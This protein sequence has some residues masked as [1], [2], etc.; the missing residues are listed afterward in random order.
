MYLIQTC[1]GGQHSSLPTIAPNTK[2]KWEKSVQLKQR[3]KTLIFLESLVRRSDAMTPMRQWRQ[4]YKDPNDAMMSMRQWSC[5]YCLKYNYFCSNHS[6]TYVQL[7]SV[8]RC[9]WIICVF[10]KMW[11]ESIFLGWIIR[12]TLWAVWCWPSLW[13]CDQTLLDSVR[14]PMP[15]SI[16]LQIK[17]QP[18]IM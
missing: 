14:H 9:K 6:S 1:L 4:W 7:H 8:T 5:I 2:K 18:E 16:C 3:R 11:L 10:K 12:P 15:S 17:V 13:S